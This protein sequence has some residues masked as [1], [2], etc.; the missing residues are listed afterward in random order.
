MYQNV[1][2][3][4]TILRNPT[5]IVAF[6]RSCCYKYH[7]LQISST[8]LLNRKLEDKKAEP[9]KFQICESK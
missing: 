9:V 4:K 5:K 7:P 3:V 6:T 8:Q 1:A 2:M